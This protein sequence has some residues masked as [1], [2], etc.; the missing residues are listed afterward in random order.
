MDHPLCSALWRRPRVDNVL[1]RVEFLEFLEIDV[2]NSHVPSNDFTWPA[3][4]DVSLKKLWL[5]QW[6]HLLNNITC[7]LE[8]LAERGACKE[9]YVGD[10]EHAVGSIVP[11]SSGKL[12]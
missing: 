2:S 6:D 7:F 3:V 9:S 4:H 12:V 5:R 11:I 8:Q 1:Q 10:I